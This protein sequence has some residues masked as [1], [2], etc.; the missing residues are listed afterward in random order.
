[1]RRQGA[2]PRR[3]PRQGRRR[4][5]RQEPG[6]GDR[7]PAGRILGMQ[8]VTHQTGPEGQKVRK[9]LIE[10]AADIAQ[11]LYVAVILDRQS[12]KPVRDRVARRAAWTSR[13][14][15]HKT[16]RRSTASRSIR[17]SASCRSRR[18]ASRAGWASRAT[19]RRGPRSWSR[20]SVA[21]YLDTDASLA[22]IN[23]LM[24]TGEGDVMALDAKMNF[25]D[26]ALFRHKDIV[27]M[28][29]LAEEN[30]LEVE[31][32]QVQPQLHQA[33]RRDRLHGQ[34]RRPGHG[35]DGHHQAR[36]RVAGQLPR[37]R[38]LG[39]AGGGRRTPSAS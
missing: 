11:E 23:P 22:E 24:I 37:R 34:R 35:D 14:S 26:N 4:E 2:D 8:L 31:A 7:E 17:S 16:R 30:P 39:L 29:D 21:A 33:R 15:P 32:S 18:G 28:R 9:V 36:R 1:M 6:R 20:R 12:G 10:E 25:D 5:A 27:A 13:R 38:R 19:S 3:R